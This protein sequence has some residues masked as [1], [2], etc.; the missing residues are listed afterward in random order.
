VYCL[1]DT[2]R[3]E[4]LDTIRVDQSV[5]CLAWARDGRYL[6]L[7][8]KIQQPRKLV[9]GGSGR[10]RYAD[11][12]VPGGAAGQV[13]LWD[14]R[15]G[16][17]RW[18]K[19]AH[20]KGVQALAFSP[21]GSLLATASSGEGFRVYEVASGS[22]VLGRL[23]YEGASFGLAFSPDGRTLAVSN[24]RNGV[25]LWDLDTEK[26]VSTGSLG[27]WP[28][29]CS[30]SPDGA[31]LA[32]WPDQ[33]ASLGA[34]PCQLIFWNVPDHSVRASYSEE[35]FQVVWSQNAFFVATLEPEA[36]VTVRD[37]DGHERARFRWLR[38]PPVDIAFSADGKSLITVRPR[39]GNPVQTWPLSGVI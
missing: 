19:R 21:D 28:V 6:A 24:D 38:Y 11:W 29:A 25:V 16:A 1:R 3:E 2:R 31:T 12:L 7:G 34:G 13:T 4:E 20:K 23:G 30:F 10:K 9:P 39:P 18:S 27:F 32:L 33:T 8:G 36:N 5:Q 26:Q 37:A 15:R 35:V 17:E 22:Q 14:V